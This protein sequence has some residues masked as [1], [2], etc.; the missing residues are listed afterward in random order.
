MS[1]PF[2][3]MSDT[4]QECLITYLDESHQRSFRGGHRPPVRP[5]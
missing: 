3:L 4:L 1:Q 2:D 5:G